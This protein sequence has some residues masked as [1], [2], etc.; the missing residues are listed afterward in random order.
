MIAKG[1][2]QY[3]LKRRKMTDGLKSS[4]ISDKRVIEAM[5]K[6]PRHLFM[7]EAL[8]A[9]AYEDHSSPIGEGQTISK[10]STVALM[11]Q[12]SA[13]SGGEK[14]LEIGTGSGYQTAVLSQLC[15]RVVTIER[16][17]SLSFRA[18]K[19]LNDLHIGNVMYLV[20]D[21]VIMAKKHS[22]FD[23]ILVTAGAPEIPVPLALQLKEGG[24]IVIPVTE[25]SEQRIMVAIRFGDRF[26][27]TRQ[28]PCA[29]VPLLGKYGYKEKQGPG[30]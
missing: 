25:G 15:D 18:R 17:N 10:P 11:S 16:I 21:G 1:A 6:T 14:V 29:F 30:A 12:L 2:D 28:E 4:G 23:V 5:G 20:G 22:P 9:R 19:I 8:R 26:K 7:E 3:I 13:L 24:R 27:V